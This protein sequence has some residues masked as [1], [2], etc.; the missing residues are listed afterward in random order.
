MTKHIH[1]SLRFKPS[2]I[3]TPNRTVL[4][5][6]TNKQSHDD[7]RLSNNELQWLKRRAEGGFGIVTTAAAH[8]SKDG[9]SWKGELGVFDD[10]HI[11][12]LSRLARDI[13]KEKSLLIAQLFHGGLQ[14]DENLT[15]ST[16]ISASR[17][18]SRLSKTGFSKQASEKEIIKV[19]SDFKDAACRCHEAGFDG[20]EIHGAHGYL[21]TQFLG[22]KTNLRSD[23]WGGSLNNRSRLLIEILRTMRDELPENFIV[24]VRISPEIKTMG[25]RLDD[26]IELAKK[27]SDMEIDFI[28]ISC[29]DVFKRSIEYPNINKTLTEWFTESCENLPTVISTGGVW[30]KE[31]ADDLLKQGADLVGVGRVGIGYPDWA[32]AVMKEKYDPKKPPFTSK[33]LKQAN[34]SDVFIDYMRKWDGFVA[35]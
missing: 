13:H 9:Q 16:P 11:D 27:I 22:I 31:N 17:T 26:S 18:K 7:G 29:W 32:K 14:A 15:G 2:G 1:E 5:A 10:I 28:H 4:A 8:V 6:M 25:I 19:I 24:G 33:Q 12:G 3:V 30:S 34:L 35:D 23:S 20:V 21:I